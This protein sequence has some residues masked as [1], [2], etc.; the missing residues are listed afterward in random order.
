MGVWGH[1]TTHI[2]CMPIDSQQ[3]LVVNTKTL[4]GKNVQSP[5]LHEFQHII[6]QLLADRLPTILY[7][8]HK[9]P[10][11]CKLAI[12]LIN[13]PFQNTL[14]VLYW[15]QVRRAGWPLH[16][17]RIPRSLS[18]SIF[19]PAACAGALSCWNVQLTGMWS[20]VQGSTSFFSN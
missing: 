17:N 6:G 20:S 13:S 19:D 11:G 14:Q 2:Y 8:L 1:R 5:L 18:Q 12:I 16:N 10:R 4:T 3:Y 7:E 9:V 15:I